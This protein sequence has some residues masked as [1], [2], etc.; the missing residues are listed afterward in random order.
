[1]KSEK[2]KIKNDKGTAKQC[3]PALFTQPQGGC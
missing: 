2:L 3:K 1:M